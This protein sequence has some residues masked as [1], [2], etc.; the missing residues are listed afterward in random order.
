MKIWRLAILLIII[1]VGYISY[2]MFSYY[3]PPTKHQPYAIPQDRDDTLRIAYIGDSWAF[4][5]REHN[6]QISKILKDTMHRP[7][8]VHSY[9]ICGLTSKEFYENIFNNADLKHFLQKRR[10]EYCFI[11]LGINDTYKKMSTAYYQQSMD[12][13]IQF[14]LANHIHPT[15]LE[16]PNY[17]I[18]KSYNRQELSRKLLRRLSMY[19]NKT[20]L[21]C[22]Q[23]FRDALDNMISKNN[24][25]KKVSILRYLS[26]NKNGAKDWVKIYQDDGIHLNE[27]GYA[28]LDSCIAETCI[29]HYKKSHYG[30]D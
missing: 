23:L 10:Y 24:Y 21:D 1:A 15:I 28:I 14:F 19:I 2:R 7:A 6:C 25:T 4:M 17:D 5:H 13:I 11:S 30:Q 9:G 3:M 22:K 18:S 26:W 27:K 8:K 20:P 29:E 16:I 12:N